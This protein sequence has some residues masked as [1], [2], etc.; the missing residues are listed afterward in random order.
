MKKHLIAAALTAVSF[1]AQAEISANLSVGSDYRFRG[2]SQTQLDPTVQAGIDYNHASGFYVGNWNSNV[3]TEFYP[4]GRG[5]ESD[6]YA[7]FATTAGGFDLNVGILRYMYPGT[8]ADFN[9][10]EVYAGVSRGPVSF[11]VSQ[12][13]TDYFGTANSKGSRYYDLTVTVPVKGVTLLAHAGRTDVA[14]Q[15]TNDYDDFAVGVSADVAALGGLT[16][17]AKY[18]INDLTAEY[19]QANT[20][21]GEKLY[22]NALVISFTKTF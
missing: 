18:H 14:N 20:V 7:G 19:E 9:T 5:I 2:I 21:S 6:V 12:S 17:A 22:K 16:V 15:N 4:G 1:A 13:T 8:T 3:A 10:N 11:K